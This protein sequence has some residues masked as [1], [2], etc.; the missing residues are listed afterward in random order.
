MR[1]NQ[2]RSGFTLV[3]LAIVLVIIGLIVGG[4]LVGQD[5][6]KAAEIN[7]AV[8]QIS[9][10]DSGVNTFRGKYNGLPGDI[11][12]PG[13]F[14]LAATGQSAVVGRGD[15]DGVLQAGY[16]LAASGCTNANGLGGESSLFWNHLAATSLIPDSVNAISDYTTSAAISTIGD[17][18]LPQSKL[19]RGNRIHVTSVESRNFYV[20]SKFT[21]S[22]A[23]TC[24]LT[25]AVGI[26]PIQAN[27]IDKKIDDGSA[28]TGIVVSLADGAVPATIGG[29]A[30]GGS[31]AAGNCYANSTGSVYTAGNY[32]TGSDAIANTLGC[33]LRIRTSF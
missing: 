33:Q 25:A 5:L 16:T 19:G 23:T 27:S 21:A 12:N 4:V 14:G 2:S 8:S 20:I 10:Y 15:G 3:E 32:A 6:I 29:G 31:V 17:T 30:A 28:I 22:T 7:A 9:K 24:A 18:H 13:V 26:T 11:T 1:N